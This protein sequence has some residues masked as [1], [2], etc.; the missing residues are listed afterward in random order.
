[1]ILI[2]CSVILVCRAFSHCLMKE[3]YIW[4][5]NEQEQRYID[6]FPFLEFKGRV[7]GSVF[8]TK[9]LTQL[10][11]LRDGQNNSSWLVQDSESWIKGTDDSIEWCKENGH[12][13]KLFKNYSRIFLA[14]FHRFTYFTFYIKHDLE[15]NNFFRYC[16]KCFMSMSQPLS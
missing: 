6:R 7:L 13:F 1:M 8:S 16:L 11:F 12:D 2:D 9:D 10:E 5:S 14:L 15:P 4:M 3:K